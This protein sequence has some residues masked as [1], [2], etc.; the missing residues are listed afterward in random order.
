MVPP[1]TQSCSLGHHLNLALGEHFLK[2]H[3]STHT[4]IQNYQII[5]ICSLSSYIF[6]IGY[7][8]LM[9]EGNWLSK[10]VQPLQVYVQHWHVI[11]PSEYQLH[12]P[13]T[14]SDI[15]L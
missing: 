7:L 4:H 8:V 13:V 15:H 11:I 1:S 12:L 10:I 6:H 5:V 2:P 9:C 3:S 14:P